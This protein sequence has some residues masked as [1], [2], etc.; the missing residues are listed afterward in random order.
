[1][2]T[3]YK[4]NT[5]FQ[6]SVPPKTILVFDIGNSNITIGLYHNALLQRT[7]T[8]KSDKDYQTTQLYNFINSQLGNSN[9]DSIATSSVV[10]IISKTLE[11]VITTCY[12]TPYIFVNTLTPLGLT[13]PIADPSH[14]GSDM[15][16]DAYSAVQLYQTN[17]II[18]DLGTATTIQ[19]VGADGYFHGYVILPGLF[20]ATQSLF[21][22]TAQLKPFTL[23]TP[24]S[25]LGITTQD[26]I[27]S[28]SVY[29][30]VFTIEKF[31]EKIKSEYHHLGEIKTILTGGVTPLIENDIKGIDIVNKT[32]LLDGLARI[33]AMELGVRS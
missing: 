28:G 23:E 9:I 12:K 7:F 10:P 25:L 5:D 2:E 24:K 31:I 17:C 19:L 21:A 30:Q 14:I 4:K 1:M 32:L 18:A 16:V 27:T 11:Q 3:Q 20:T 8:I 15:I 33:G 22:S 13:F 29:S 6:N 26:A